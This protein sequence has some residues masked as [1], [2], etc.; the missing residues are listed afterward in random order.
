MAVFG[1][2]LFVPRRGYVSGVDVPR[3]EVAFSG[4]WLDAVVIDDWTKAVNLQHWVLSVLEGNH[5]CGIHPISWTAL[6][7]V[8]QWLTY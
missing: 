3:C 2:T 5:S 8:S 6:E 4:S 1:Y 7:E